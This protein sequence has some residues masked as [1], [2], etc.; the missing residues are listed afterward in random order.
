MRKPNKVDL[1]FLDTLSASAADL[2]SFYKDRASYQEGE[3][4]FSQPAKVELIRIPKPER[5][6]YGKAISNTQKE[7]I[8]MLEV[9]YRNLS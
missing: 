2:P 4:Q 1:L 8:K 5:D 9:Y 7:P 3:V 6:L